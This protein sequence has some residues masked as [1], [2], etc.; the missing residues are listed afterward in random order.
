MAWTIVKPPATKE[1][2]TVSTAEDVVRSGFAGGR[3]GLESILATPQDL[4]NLFA[5][6]GS[7]AAS[8]LGLMTP[9][10]AQKYAK[11]FDI[12]YL[13]SSEDI[14]SV[15]SKIIGPSYEPQTTA[16]KFAGTMAEFAGGSIGNPAGGFV[17]AAG[18]HLAEG[19]LS[20]LASEGAG[21]L[22]EGSRFEPIA[23]LIAGLGGGSAAG[24]LAKGVEHVASSGRRAAE[25]AAEDA[26]R[27]GA[28][29]VQLTRGQR[30]GDV[31]QQMQEQLILRAGA[32]ADAEAR[33]RQPAGYPRRRHR[34]QGHHR[35]DAR[36]D[37]GRCRQ[38]AQPA[39]H[40]PRAV[41]ARR[42]R[43]GDPERA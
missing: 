3:R 18:R 8:R 7:A 11:G 19:A 42:G 31:A 4:M 40:L 37:A 41:A 6:G 39:D 26:A 10:E 16:G 15:T 38:F 9:E 35:A 30:T 22:T 17:R 14:H 20:G 28:A 2:E 25:A 13:P 1:P 23:R 27:A 5:M 43:P 12:P 34:H 21:Q 32:A 24:G 36:G 29:G 33:G